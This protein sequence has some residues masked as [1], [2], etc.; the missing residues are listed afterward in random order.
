MSRPPSAGPSAA[1]RLLTVA[2]SREPDVVTARQRA[3][4]LAQLLGFEHLDQIRIATSTSEIARNAVQYAG[5]GMVE[6]SFVSEPE[7]PLFLVTVT[8]AGRGIVETSAILQEQYHS[9]TGLGLGLTGTRQLMDYFSLDA[10]PGEGTTVTFGKFLPADVDKPDIQQIARL[11]EHFAADVS[12]NSTEELRCRNREL[13]DA[14]NTVHWQEV[15]LQRRQTELDRLNQELEETNRGVV[16]LYAELDDRAAALRRADEV[17]SRF[18]SH[19]SHEFRTPLNSIAALTELLLRHVDGDLT[20]EQEKQVMLVRHSALE[21][22]EMVND[23][24]DLAKVEAGKIDLRCGNVEVSKLFGAL[25]GLMRPLSTDEAVNLIF[26]DPPD[27]LIVYSDEGKLGQILRNLISN[28]LKFTQRG[29]IRVSVTC[30]RADV[31]FSVSDTGIGIAAEDQERIFQEFSQVEHSLQRKVKGTGLGLPLSRKLSELLGGTLT[32][33]SI[34]DVGSTFR[35]TLPVSTRRPL[36]CRDGGSSGD[37]LTAVPNGSRREKDSSRPAAAAEQ[38][39]SDHAGA[40]TILVIDDEEVARYLIRQFFRGTNYVITEASGGSEGL[41][42]AR[43]D[44]PRL[45]ILDLA[46]P[47]PNGFEVLEELKAD[48]ATAHIPIVIHTSRALQ[49]ADLAQL[50]GRHAAVW[51]K[52]EAHRDHAVAV[53]RELLR[54]PN[55]FS[56]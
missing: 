46:M 29:E 32:L 26:E 25:R 56:E 31:V 5:S 3:R 35:L 23:L 17:K 16:A 49:P 15:E 1:Q 45:I 19:M 21:L 44:Q 53:I 36:E 9:R 22:F 51:P 11:T 2:V 54:E 55:L 14:L 37:C 27:D 4:H 30:N 6:F 52:D 18:L 50:R 41:E 8:D 42:R 24:L 48:A 28:A 7:R 34:Q 10:R 33:S 40:G 38:D 47:D 20:L 12:Q 13:L 39:T 43:F